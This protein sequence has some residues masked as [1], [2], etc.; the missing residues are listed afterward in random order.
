MLGVAVSKMLLL[1]SVNADSI[2]VTVITIVIFLGVD[3]PLCTKSPAHQV[4]LWWYCLSG[5]WHVFMYSNYI[6]PIMLPTDYR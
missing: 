1:I 6:L 2:I 3:G 4:I 5:E